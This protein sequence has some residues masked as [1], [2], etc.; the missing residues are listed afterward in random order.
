MLSS[1]ASKPARCIHTNDFKC[2]FFLHRYGGPDSYQVT[3]K[4]AV[5]WGTYLVTNKS[6]IYA[7]IDGR[8]SGLKGDDMLFSVYRNLGTSEVLDQIN[9]TK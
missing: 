1:G 6:V 5:D 7:A 4:F 2:V 9:V 8:G 3:E